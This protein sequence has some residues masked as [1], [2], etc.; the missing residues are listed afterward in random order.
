MNDSEYCGVDKNCSFTGEKRSCKNGEVCFNGKCEQNSCTDSNEMLCVLNDVKQCVNITTD[1]NCGACGNKCTQHYSC[2]NKKCELTSCDQGMTL[3]EI[4]DKK[5]CI[6][7]S[8]NAD[9]C[10]DCNN[11]CSKNIPASARSVGCE[12]NEC[13]YICDTG[14]EN[15][16]TGNTRDTI[17]CQKY[18]CLE[19]EDCTSANASICNLATHTCVECSAQSDCNNKVN[20]ATL[21]FC[22]NGQCYVGMCATGHHVSSDK[23]SCEPDTI[24]DCGAQHKNCTEEQGLASS[25]E[26]SV[27]CV[28][29]E[30]KAKACI[31]HQYYL[32]NGKCKASDN[33]NC[34]SK[35]SSCEAHNG[36]GESDSV[37]NEYI[38][39]VNNGKCELKCQDGKVLNNGSCV[40]CS[41]N[42]EC[43]D[44]KKCSG[45]GSSRSKKCYC[46]NDKGGG[47]CSPGGEC[48][49]NSCTY[50]SKDPMSNS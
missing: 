14:Y 31:Q 42:E 30:C 37:L 19:N 26:N 6:N 12:S 50:P 24:R 32:D 10:G 11:K 18:A 34:G 45:F 29:G 1:D 36:T 9:H 16:G 40:N 20:N 3:C 27:E 25:D 46:P 2:I 5:E 13:R 47:I 21:T 38:C 23:K 15:K 49:S 8:G 22:D 44:S 33:K 7:L 28:A 43:G 17:N 41:N 35:G 4:G 48:E 39:N